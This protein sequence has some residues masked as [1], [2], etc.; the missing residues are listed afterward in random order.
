[1][2]RGRF[3]T[4]EGGEGA[5][6][7]TL[8]AALAGALTA[9]GL[10][11]TATREPGGTPGAEAIRE[12]LLHGPVDRWSPVSET[13]LFYAARADHVQRV[14]EPALA[15]GAWVL[16]DR[17]A[18]ST[19]AYQGAAGGVDAARIAAIHKAALG[20]FGPDLTLIIDLDPAAGLSRTVQR[21]EAATRFE[22]NGGGFHDRLRQ[23]FLGIAAREP[24]RCA[25]LDGALAPEQLAQAALAEID[26]RLLA[27]A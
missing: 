4:L 11:V 17:F 21:G 24:D 7:S 16:C 5:G 10:Q 18:D 19:A 3:I 23:A 12:L 1:M 20:D 13:L 22:R 2:A 6:K 14:I 15:R 26:R 27:A 8:L 9:R 25:V